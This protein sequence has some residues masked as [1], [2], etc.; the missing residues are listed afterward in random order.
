VR[1]RDA[2]TLAGQQLRRRPGRV[3]LTVGAVALAAALLTA[4]LTMAT[5]AQARV[6]DQV[7]S[8]GPLSGIK[9]AAAEPNLDQIDQDQPTPGAPRDLDAT[10]LNRLRRLPGVKA[11]FP[12]VSVG[13]F[14]VE[15][16]RRPDGAPLRPSSDTL[17][18]VDLSRPDLLPITVV[19]GRL[20]APDATDEAAVAPGYLERLG[21]ARTDAAKVIGT[22][23]EYASGRA[24]GDLPGR[25]PD[26][27]RRLIRGRWVRATIVGVVAQDAGP[28]RILVPLAAATAARDWTANGPDQ[29]RVLRLS[30]SPYSGAFVIADGIDAV[31]GVRNEITSVGFATSAPENL[32]ASVRRYLRVVEI[33]LSG[34]GVIALVVATLGIANAMLAAVRERRREIGVLKAIGARDGDVLRIFVMEAGSLGFVGGVLG[35]ALGIGAAQSVVAVVNRYLTA[36]GLTGVGLDVPLPIIA[37]GVLGSMVLALLGGTLPARRAARL[38]PREAVAA[39]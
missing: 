27:D 6:L 29:G 37:L 16:D 26:G 4:L 31:P 5:T 10:G 35:T 1:W 7:A 21:L 9:V 28:G 39:G 11:A 23:I 25:D 36:Q 15:P 24:S 22:E 8:G 3:A 14:V 12:V 19:A 33:V 38:S 2:V 20:P 30:T 18:G 34:I 17:V 13:V 32:I